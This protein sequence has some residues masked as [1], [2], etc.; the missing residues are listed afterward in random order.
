MLA[1][2]S[3]QDRDKCEPGLFSSEM[4]YAQTAACPKLTL[5]LLNQPIL[6][7]RT[8]AYL[9]VGTNFFAIRQKI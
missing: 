6:C 9:S 3:A 4:T 5:F 2:K 1:V 7:V 8:I